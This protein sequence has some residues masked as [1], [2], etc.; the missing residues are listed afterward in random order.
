MPT[1]KCPACAHRNL[2]SSVLK[3]CINCG[4][5]L[6]A[7]TPSPPLPEEPPSVIRMPASSRSPSHSPLHTT[8]SQA[9][10]PPP[11][12]R[13][14]KNERELQP[15]PYHKEA[16]LQE[17]QEEEEEE[18]EETQV[19]RYPDTPYQLSQEFEPAE[20]ITTIVTGQKKPPASPAWMTDK[21]PLGFPR[22]P[23]GIFGTVIQVQSQYEHNTSFDTFGAF[24]KQLRDALLA[25]PYERPNLERE[26]VLVT[27]VRIYTSSG[28]QEDIRF[29]GYLRKANI[30]LGDT[31]SLWGRKRYGSF[32]VRRAYNHT[33]KGPITTSAMVSPLPFLLLLL[34]MMIAFLLLT[35]WLH[36]H[37]PF[38]PKLF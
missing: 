16:G 13:L 10:G 4:A 21:L 25:V 27:T 24:F 34:A 30:A 29:Q 5:P 19:Q 37:I 38:L 11:T 9:A 7:Q 12:Y 18:E 3:I 20:T 14:Q 26:Q 8:F 31:L 33:S 1:I 36:I 6:P 35:S 2:P 32:V 17:Y 22:R 23:P 15:Y 28:K